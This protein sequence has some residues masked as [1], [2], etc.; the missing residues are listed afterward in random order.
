MPV[1]KYR[2]VEDMPEAAIGV[3]LDPRNLRRACELSAM[4]AR[5]ALRR[6]PPG[7]HRYGSV[8]AADAARDAW[9]RLERPERS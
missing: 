5:L 2:S 3:A 4:A 7:V 1:R 6:F 9:E 8:A